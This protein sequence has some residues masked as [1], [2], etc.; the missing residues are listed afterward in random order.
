MTEDKLAIVI[1]RIK[2]SKMAVAFTG[3]G[4]S[5]DS[6]IPPFRGPNGLWSKYDPVIL[7][8]SYFQRN[9]KE[10]WRIIKEIFYDFFGKAKPNNFHYLLAKL[11]KMNLLEAIITQ[12]ID[13]LHQSAG[14]KNVIEFHGRSSHLV[15]L[16]CN[17]YFEANDILLSELPPICPDCDGLLKPDFVFFGE[18]I[19][20]VAL[21]KSYYYSQ[22]ADLFI[23]AGTTG[24]I[25]PASQIP[26]LAKNNGAY[27]IEFNIEPSNY[28]NSVTDLFIQS[29]ADIVGKEIL[30]LLTKY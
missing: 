2:N 5:V 22:K 14:S 26:Y 16:D 6:G 9:P 25:M 23:L 8:I 4:V 21:D 15:C 10:S 7:D 12:N 29:R 3:A 30:E 20:A 1:D 27:I 24:E 13:G 19:P 28:T 11:E 17:K 18:P